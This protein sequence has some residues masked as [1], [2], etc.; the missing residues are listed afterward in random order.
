MIVFA[1]RNVEGRSWI[2]EAVE[3]AH[4]HM[5]NEKVVVVDSDSPD[6]S[7]F[8]EVDAEVL[9]VA[10]A[11]YETGAWWTAFEAFPDE[12][13][14]FFLHD[15]LFIQEPI[16]RKPFFTPA[17]FEGWFGCQGHHVEQT[18]NMCAQVGLT[19][20]H[21]FHSCLGSMFGCE[22]SL[23]TK[24]AMSDMS[25]LRPTDRTGSQVM[26]R[27]WGI[28]W[29]SLGIDVKASALMSYEDIYSGKGPLLKNLGGARP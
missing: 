17:T 7:Y 15:N 22:R 19:I 27:I 13:Y 3:R 5:P 6:K 4:T 12:D 29:A 18:K 24:L 25:R 16:E 21:P 23:L 10:N 1:C 8:G 14:F 9:D 26:E 2:R 28:A 11:C 20:P